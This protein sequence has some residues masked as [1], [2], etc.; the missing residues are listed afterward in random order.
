MRLM[1]LKATLDPDAPLPTRD[2]TGGKKNNNKRG[3]LGKHKSGNRDTATNEEKACF[4]NGRGIVEG[5]EDDEEVVGS[6]KKGLRMVE[7]E[8]T[9]MGSPVPSDAASSE[10][11]EPL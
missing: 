5:M 9:A 11:D 6:E 10:K 1:R 4:M 3:R 2:G 7:R 8:A